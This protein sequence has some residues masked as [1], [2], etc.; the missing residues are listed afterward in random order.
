MQEIKKELNNRANNIKR[1]CDSRFDYNLSDKVLKN[2]YFKTEF[3]QKQFNDV[4]DE[5]DNEYTLQEK[6][7][8]MYHFMRK[9]K[10]T[11]DKLN[12]IYGNYSLP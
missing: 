4:I 11:D 2:I 12:K 5:V 9:M 3:Y 1:Y 7:Y 6:I 10:Q 8:Y